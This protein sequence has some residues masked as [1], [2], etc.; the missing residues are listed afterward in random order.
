MALPRHPPC[1][2]PNRPARCVSGFWTR[3]VVSCRVVSCSQY[4]I[5]LLCDSQY[6][7]VIFAQR[8]NEETQILPRYRIYEQRLY[9]R[10][11]DLLHDGLIKTPKLNIR[12]QNKNTC[13]N[14][15]LDIPQVGRVIA[16]G[17]A[18]GRGRARLR[19]NRII[20]PRNNSPP[21]SPR[22]SKQ[23]SST[24]FRKHEQ[25]KSYSNRRRNKING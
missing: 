19:A 18:A 8:Q 7:H 10:R 9:G 25:A 13:R 12:M 23:I 16:P 4:C 17:G 11:I 3:Q 6:W 5:V 22:N 21:F 1:A 24:C 15:N 2:A 20:R 14:Q